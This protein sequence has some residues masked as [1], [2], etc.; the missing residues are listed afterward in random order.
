MLDTHDSRADQQ[1][2]HQREG[3]AEPNPDFQIR[4]LHVSNSLLYRTIKVVAKQPMLQPERCAL[5]QGGSLR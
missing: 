1:R 4:N 3:G 5:S 2:D